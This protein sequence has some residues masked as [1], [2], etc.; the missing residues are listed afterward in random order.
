MVCLALLPSPAALFLIR[1]SEEAA[2]IFVHLFT[3]SKIA[4]HMIDR[5]AELAMPVE[6]VVFVLY[7]RTGLLF[8]HSLQFPSFKEAKL[9]DWLQENYKSI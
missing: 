1:K 2:F 7:F 5:E 4:Y 9:L 3:R 8:L 6:N